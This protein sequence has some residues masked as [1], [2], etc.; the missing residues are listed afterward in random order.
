MLEALFIDMPSLDRCR[1]NRT[2]MVDIDVIIFFWV[3]RCALAIN[4]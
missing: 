3:K 4:F 2:I 1:E